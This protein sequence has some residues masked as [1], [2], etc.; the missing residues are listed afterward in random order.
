MATPQS[1]TVV[2]L[3]SAEAA[4]NYALELNL[5]GYVLDAVWKE[6][7]GIF[8]WR[9]RYGLSYHPIPVQPP[10]PAKPTME[11]IV[12]PVTIRPNALPP[13]KPTLELI[14]GPVSN[15]PMR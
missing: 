4:L 3:Y 5:A 10:P 9:V 15:R 14:I 7:Y 11:F 2:Y 12:G 13:P 8:Y 6:Y 1:S